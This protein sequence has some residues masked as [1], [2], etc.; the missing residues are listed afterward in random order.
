VLNQVVC[1]A[2]R[3]TM[4]ARVTTAATGWPL[5]IGLPSVTM[6][7]ATPQAEK[8]QSPSPVRAKPHWT[9]SATKSAPAARATSTS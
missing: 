1:A 2:K 6:S 9:S 4:S 3:S 8:P 5:P 7:G